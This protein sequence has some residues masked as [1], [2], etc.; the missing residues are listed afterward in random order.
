MLA[1][2]HFYS[3][4]EPLRANEGT[5]LGGR[6]PVRGSTGEFRGNAFRG[7][8]KNGGASGQNGPRVGPTVSHPAGGSGAII[9]S[10]GQGGGGSHGGGYS[11]GGGVGSVAVEGAPVEVVEASPAVAARHTLAVVVEASPGGGGGAGG[12]HH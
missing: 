7:G 9:M 5:T 11:G 10:H 12:G 6:Y 1:H 4:R 3:G 2:H 8:E